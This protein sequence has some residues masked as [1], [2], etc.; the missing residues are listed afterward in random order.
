MAYLIVCFKKNP[1]MNMHVDLEG[2]EQT[3]QCDQPRE[4]LNKLIN[5]AI[6]AQENFQWDS[7]TDSSM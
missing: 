7:F 4:Q 1:R 2:N 5:L 6:G 3:F